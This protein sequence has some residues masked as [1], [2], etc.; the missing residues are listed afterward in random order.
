[1]EGGIWPTQKFWCGA[2]YVGEGEQLSRNR[3][4]NNT[5]GVYSLYIIE[6]GYNLKYFLLQ[7]ILEIIYK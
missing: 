7:I 1:M 2:P 4:D 6:I 3:Q 5:Q